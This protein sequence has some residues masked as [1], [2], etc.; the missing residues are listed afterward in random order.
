VRHEEQNR[1]IEKVVAMAW[2]DEA[3]KHRLLSDPARVLRAQGVS[4]PEGVE[5]RIVEDTAMV[6]HVVLPV[7][8]SS[9]ELSEEQFKAYG[10]PA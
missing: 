3:F 9:Q 6:L 10:R 2:A 8:P 7:K 4:V 5:V 1:N